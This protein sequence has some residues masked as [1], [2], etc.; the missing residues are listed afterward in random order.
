MALASEK[1]RLKPRA[2]YVGF[3]VEYVT[4]GTDFSLKYF[5]SS[6]LIIIILLILIKLNVVVEWLKLLLHI[7]KAL[8]SNLDPE[9][10][11]PE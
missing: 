9:T 3:E 2:V 1:P 11:Y 8:G 5:S 7:Q 6:L 10:K 4:P